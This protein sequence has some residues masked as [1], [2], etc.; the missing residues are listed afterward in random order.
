[1]FCR[2][3]TKRIKQYEHQPMVDAEVTAGST[4][5]QLPTQSE[6]VH[7]IHGEID[8]ELPL[9]ALLIQDDTVVDGHRA[10]LG[11]DGRP[12]A[13]G[14]GSIIVVVIA[15]AFLLSATMGGNP[16]FRPS[17]LKRDENNPYIFNKITVPI[18]RIYSC[19]A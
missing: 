15:V 16:F 1:M 18:E 13:A 4:D 17:S 3:E 6:T 12:A 9:W 14:V 11:R 19:E 8:G 7:R 5:A 10:A 2:A